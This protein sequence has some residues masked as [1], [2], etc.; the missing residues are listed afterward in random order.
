VIQAADKLTRAQ[1]FFD[2]RT[3]FL[4]LFA[5]ADS[6]SCRKNKA[7]DL[8][9][10]LSAKDAYGLASVLAVLAQPALPVPSLNVDHGPHPRVNAALDPGFSGG[11]NC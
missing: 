6:P 1:I 5:D 9:T 3:Q 11:Q 10:G 2:E 7:R 4:P 8:G